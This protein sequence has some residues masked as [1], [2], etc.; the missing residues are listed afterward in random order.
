MA[1]QLSLLRAE[2]ANE[3]F[4][5]GELEAAMAAYS[6]ITL[7]DCSDAAKFSVCNNRGAL[8]LQRGNAT[9]ALSDFTEALTVKPQSIDALHNRASALKVIGNAA[10]AL[11]GFDACLEIDVEFYL[12]LCGKSECLSMLSRFD[13]AITVS[14]TAIEL[15]PDQTRAFVNR[16]FAKLKSGMYVSLSLSPHVV[17]CSTSQV[18]LML[19][20]IS[21]QLLQLVMTL[22]K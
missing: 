1:G 19:S 18:L 9:E 7:S 2:A 3:L 22:T 8:N 12:G 14:T 15:S 6:S 16:G 5:A 11:A 17:M 20:W 4:K 10:E 21:N 13:E